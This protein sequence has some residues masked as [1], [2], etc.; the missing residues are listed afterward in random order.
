MLFT[1]FSKWNKKR[2]ILSNFQM[3]FEKKN[4]RFFLNFCP[5]FY[6][7]GR[8]ALKKQHQCNS[9]KAKTLI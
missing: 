1:T 9:L 7:K 5:F 4:L 3:F 6:K 8:F 2:L